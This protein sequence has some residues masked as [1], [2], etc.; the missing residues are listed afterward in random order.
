MI[1]I[2]DFRT[3]PFEKKCDVVMADTNFIM[4]RKMGDAKV[5]LYHSGEFYIEVYYSCKYKKVLMINAFDDV[6]GLEPYADIVSLAD[7]GF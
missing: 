5:Y 2:E 6:Y 3:A 4:S 1:S 7:L